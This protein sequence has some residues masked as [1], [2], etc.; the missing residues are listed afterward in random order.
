[1]NRT[2]GAQRLQIGVAQPLAIFAIRLHQNCTS[3]HERSYQG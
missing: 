1:L 2:H 3:V